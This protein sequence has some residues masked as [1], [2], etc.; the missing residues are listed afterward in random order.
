[1]ISVLV[2]TDN[3]YDGKPPS[4]VIVKGEKKLVLKKV[5]STVY[6]KAKAYMTRYGYPD[7]TKTEKLTTEF[8]KKL[9]ESMKSHLEQENTVFEELRFGMEDVSKETMLLLDGF[10]AVAIELSVCKTITV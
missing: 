5:F 2:H 8:K 4:N 3:V 10:S 7:K 9:T 1:M 6:I